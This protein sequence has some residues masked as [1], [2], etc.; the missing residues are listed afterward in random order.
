MVLPDAAPGAGGWPEVMVR[1]TRAGGFRK[2]GVLRDRHAGRSSRQR[3][4]IK[5]LLVVA[6]VPLADLIAL[7]KIPV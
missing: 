7:E 1:Y 4:H 2:S 5:Q 6:E 3:F